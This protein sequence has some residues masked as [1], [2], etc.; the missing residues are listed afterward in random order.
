MAIYALDE[1]NALSGKGRRF[2]L[3][4]RYDGATVVLNSLLL[5]TEENELSAAYELQ[6]LGESYLRVLNDVSAGTTRY[7]CGW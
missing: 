2:T 5:Q 3:R 7:F 1:T 6:P 4:I